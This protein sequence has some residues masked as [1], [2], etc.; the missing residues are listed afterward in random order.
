MMAAEDRCQDLGGM[1][2]VRGVT[3][4]RLR[5]RTCPNCCSHSGA[6]GFGGL[7]DEKE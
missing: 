2:V 5:R 1:R 7:R 3:R 6:G 4:G